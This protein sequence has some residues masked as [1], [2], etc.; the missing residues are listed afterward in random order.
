ML[1]VIENGVDDFLQ[2]AGVLVLE[3]IPERGVGVVCC[4]KFVEFRAEVADTEASIP[5]CPLSSA[6]YITHVIH[7]NHY[8]V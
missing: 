7:D 2:L 6:L 8:H 4:G 1:V 5:G 3:V